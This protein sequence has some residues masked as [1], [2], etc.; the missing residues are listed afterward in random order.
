MDEGVD[1]RLRHFKSKY[2]P[3]LVNLVQSNK[4]FITNIRNRK[5]DLS[6]KSEIKRS[7]LFFIPYVKNIIL[8]C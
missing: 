7:S 3:D 6:F 1:P 4:V 5:D 8:C 2:N